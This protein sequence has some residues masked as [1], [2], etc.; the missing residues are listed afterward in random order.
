MSFSE[1]ADEPLIINEPKMYSLNK[2][3]EYISYY[4]LTRLPNYTFLLVIDY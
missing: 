4:R 2:P 3:M 1:Y